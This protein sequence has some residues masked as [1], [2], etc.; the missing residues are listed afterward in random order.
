MSRIRLAIVALLVAPAGA[1]ALTATPAAA[2]CP[3]RPASLADQAKDASGVFTGTVADRTESGT[4]VTFVVEP[5]RVYKGQVAESPVEVTTD[6]RR[7]R[8]GQP[9]L[10]PGNDYVFFVNR[11][12][13]A[14]S[15][16]RRSGTAR[17]TDE[18]VA[19]V[20][21]LLG[22][23]RPAVEPEPEPVAFTTV[24]GEPATLQRVAAPGAAL[25]IVGLLGLLLVA[26]RARRA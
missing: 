21:Q 4:T 6:S 22:D 3:V 9:G 25:V 23:G 11:D 20:E 10:K 17:A 16:D 8:C 19:Q 24:G 1:V 18:L 14:L 2:A 12:G 13:D 7:A 26:W 15:T 5:D